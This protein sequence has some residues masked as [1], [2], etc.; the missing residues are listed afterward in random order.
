MPA[1]EREALDVELDSRG[2]LDGARLACRVTRYAQWCRTRK[3]DP[4]HLAHRPALTR[5]AERMDRPLGNLKSRAALVVVATFELLTPVTGAPVPTGR[6]Y[7]PARCRR[8][9]Y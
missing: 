1:T 3:I 8:Q 2:V 7:L 5:R 9:F 4:A 6:S